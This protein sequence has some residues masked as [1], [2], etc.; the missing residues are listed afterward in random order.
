[1]IATYN[2]LNFDD[3]TIATAVVDISA[4]ESEY[5]ALLAIEEGGKAISEYLQALLRGGELLRAEEVRNAYWPELP[6]GDGWLHGPG[7]RRAFAF[8]W[9]DGF[10]PQG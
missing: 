6:Y 9:A 8:R 3:Q 5:G 2:I 1:M 4:D 7:I 10:E